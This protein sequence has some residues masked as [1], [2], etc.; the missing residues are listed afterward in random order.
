MSG[1]GYLKYRPSAP[2]EYE[3]RFVTSATVKLVEPNH[4]GI[5]VGLYKQEVL[6]CYY[7]LQRDRY[8]VRYFDG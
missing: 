1:T 2:V 7:R 5:V 6:Q 8:V 4:V 3:E